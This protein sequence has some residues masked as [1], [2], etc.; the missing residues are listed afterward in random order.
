MSVGERDPYTGHMTTGHE[1]NGIKE[2]NTPVPRA[3]YF[4]LIVTFIF[5]VIYW[6]LMPAWPLGSSYKVGLLGTD[7][8]QGL[9]ETLSQASAAQAPWRDAIAGQSVA[10]TLADP[11]LVKIVRSRGHQLF[12]DNCAACHGSMAQ[13]GPGFPNLVAAPFLWGGDED[14]LLETLRVG[15][16]A[17]HDETRISQMLAFGKDGML[18]R[19]DI[20]AVV[21]YVGSLSGRASAGDAAHVEHGQ[22]VF[23]ENCASCHGEDGKGMA[24]AGA[25]NLTDDFWI[26]GGDEESLYQTV[27]YGRQ[28]HMPTW[29]KRF[30]E[31]DRKLLVA[32]ILDLRAKAEAAP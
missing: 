24:E 3:V 16:N 25:P 26:Y 1:W 17:Q 4:F 23:A 5:A 13:G 10:D 30:D 31:A 8:K 28:G 18:P 32:Y 21:A 22:Q 19:A 7:H 11:D 14:T 12:G 6:L 9:A 27:Y 2:L 15:I 29:E 20:E